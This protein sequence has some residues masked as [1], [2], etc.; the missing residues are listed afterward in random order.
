M[1]LPLPR[2]G[3]WMWEYCRRMHEKASAYSERWIK[4]QTAIEKSTD[5][6]VREIVFERAAE[7][8]LRYYE[9]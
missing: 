8:G 9:I 3:S 1:M 6:N 7:Y 2:S 4:L 5:D